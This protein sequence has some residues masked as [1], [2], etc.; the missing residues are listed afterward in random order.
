MKLEHLCSQTVIVLYFCFHIIKWFTEGERSDRHREGEWNLLEVVGPSILQEKLETRWSIVFLVDKK[1]FGAV[2]SSQSSLS[3]LQENSSGLCLNEKLDL[4]VSSPRNSSGFGESGCSLY[5]LCC[6]AFHTLS[7][8][9]SLFFR[10][11][12]GWP[13]VCGKQLFWILLES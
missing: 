6:V 11:R 10:L 1:A 4:W 7:A 2:R 9:S 5:W 12:A 13:G 3:S 8:M